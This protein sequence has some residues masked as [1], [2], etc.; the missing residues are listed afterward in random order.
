MQ[1]SKN[2][3]PMRV[4]S[5]IRQDKIL[6]DDTGWRS[7]DLQPRYA[8]VFPKTI[9]TR[10]GWE[11]RSGRCESDSRRFFLL[12]KCNLSRGNWKAT[13]MLETVDGTSV[14]A[15]YEYHASHPGL[16]AHVHCDRGGVEIGTAGLDQLDRLPDGDYHRRVQSWTKD[17]FWNSAKK[18]FRIRDKAGALL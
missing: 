3:A 5:L 7:D 18:F 16:H 14:V 6:T 1:N 17:G 15:R 10:S 9:P 13:L 11:W 4:R 12:V 8:P 2:A